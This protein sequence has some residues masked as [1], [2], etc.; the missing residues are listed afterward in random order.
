MTEETAGPPAG[1]AF[2]LNSL[3]L[4]LIP[5]VSGALALALF[6]APF[7][8]ADGLWVAPVALVCWGLAPFPAALAVVFASMARAAASERLRARRPR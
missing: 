5:I 7:V 8:L 2:L 3:P 1:V 4:L 6:C